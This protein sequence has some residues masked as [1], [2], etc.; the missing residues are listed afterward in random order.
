M[1]INR[2]PEVPFAQIA[3]AA[4]RDERLSFKARGI[5][6]MVL[7]NVGEWQ[8][9][10]EW[11]EQ[12][13]EPDGRHSV[14]SALTELT[15]LGYRSVRRERMPDGR[16]ATI[17]DWFH[18]PQVSRRTENPMVGKPDGRETGGSIEHHPSE[19][20]LVEDHGRAIMRKPVEDDDPQFARFWA[21]YPRKAAKGAAR[22][23]WS[24]AVLRAEPEI[25]VEGASRYAKDPNRE[26]AFT[27]H[28]AT[29]LNADRWEDEDL[30]SRDSRGDRKTSEVAEMIRRASARDQQREIE[31]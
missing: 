20:H 30:P 19:H 15:D 24:R 6:A 13:S 12:Q 5:L 17:T 18:E 2:V 14:Q 4:L 3:N 9:T 29:W 23:A 7:S 1:S 11:I 10:A 22:R 26:D 16:I 8:A 31:G 21:A 25:I 28:P 27:A